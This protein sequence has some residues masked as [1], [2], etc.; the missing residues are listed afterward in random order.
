V[1]RAGGALSGEYVSDPMLI[2][3]GR[4]LIQ[5]ALSEL[6]DTRNYLVFWL[7]EHPGDVRQDDVMI[8]LR[9]AALAYERLRV[10][11]R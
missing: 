2:Q 1:T 6:V 8:A 9:F 11:E 10:L 5:E 3:P 4:D 7:Q